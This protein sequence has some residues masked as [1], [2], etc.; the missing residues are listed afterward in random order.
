MLVDLKDDGPLLTES[1]ICLPTLSRCTLS[2]VLL[3]EANFLRLRK[4]RS[5]QKLTYHPLISS[6][7][8]CASH[9]IHD[10]ST[11][12]TAPVSPEMLNALVKARITKRSPSL[13]DLRMVALCLISYEGTRGFS[14]S[15]PV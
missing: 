6:S 8:L 1:P 15:A 14:K 13:S 4:L 10:R 12:K 9:R 3:N 7:L 2:S 5:M 11:V